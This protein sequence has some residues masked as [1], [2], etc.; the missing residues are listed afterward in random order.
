M[1]LEERTLEGNFGRRCEVCGTRLT[2]AE[3]EDAREHGRPFLC[4]VHAAEG[5]PADELASERDEA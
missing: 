5:I 4:S 1:A 2:S 3:I